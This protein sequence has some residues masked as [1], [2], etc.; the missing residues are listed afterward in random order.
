MSLLVAKVNLSLLV[1]E[2]DLSLLVAEVDGGVHEDLQPDLHDAPYLP[3]VWMPSG[4]HDDENVGDD[5]NEED[6]GSACD[7][8]LSHLW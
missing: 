8:F 6:D 5:D 7:H 4:H 2:V 1:A 3:L